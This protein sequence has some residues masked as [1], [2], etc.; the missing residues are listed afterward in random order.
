MEIAEYL[1][2]FD[3]RY[4]VDAEDLVNKIAT[5]YPQVTQA[6]GYEPFIWP[7][8]F[9]NPLTSEFPADPLKTNF[10]EPNYP[11]PDG[12]FP[13]YDKYSESYYFTGLWEN[14]GSMLCYYTPTEGD[15]IAAFTLY[16]FTDPVIYASDINF[17]DK[18]NIFES[19]FWQKM[20]EFYKRQI[21]PDTLAKDQWAFRGYDVTNGY[22]VIGYEKSFMESIGVVGIRNKFGL[23]NSFEVAVAECAILNEKEPEHDAWLIFGIYEAIDIANLQYV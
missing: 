17:Y 7:S 19:S 14:L 10:R 22:S 11:S 16:Q 12:K 8:H 18:V 1:I 15:S 2:G 5:D 20:R 6:R 9:R 21:I 13:V 23:L 3:I 4:P